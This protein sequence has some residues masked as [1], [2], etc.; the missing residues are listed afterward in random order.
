MA[1]QFTLLMGVILGLIG[2]ALLAGVWFRG[3]VRLHEAVRAA[4]EREL[5]QEKSSGRAAHERAHALDRQLVEVNTL[6]A[7]ERRAAEEK[8][9]VLKDA[10]E[11]LSN[12]FKALANEI[13]EDKSR[14]FTEQNRTS[15][16]QLLD[17]LK[18]KLTEFQAKVE[19]VYVKESNGRSALEREVHR[20]AQ[21]NQMLSED[22]RNLTNALK[23]SHKI[24]GN[25]G[26]LVLERVLDGCG[27]RKGQ[28]YEVQVRYGAE[29]GTR[30]QPDV[31]I[32]LPEGRHLV[33]DAK[34]S[35]TAYAEYVAAE[36]EGAREEAM[37]RHVGSL[38]A[39]VAGLSGK[40]Y[41]NLPGLKTVDFVLLFVPI[42]P[43]FIAAVSYDSAILME[44]W[45]KNV[46]LVSPSTFFSVIR[47][48]SHLWS[49]EAQNRNAQEIARRGAQLYDRL[50]GFVGDLSKLGER[51]AQAQESYQGAFD[52]LHRN[53]GNVIWQAEKLRG[54]GV[55]PSKQLP[56]ALLAQTVSD[57]EPGLPPQADD[58]ETLAGS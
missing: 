19:D 17:P 15:L 58:G 30:A 9:A 23:G 28:E 37:K 14:R 6:L 55:K 33:V 46:L 40:Q 2:G 11:E 41:Q 3:R 42:E 49:Q 39:H 21:M 34:V 16:G 47:L 38:R 52:K 57:D 50:V 24:Q 1:A 22:A 5:G 4:L 10:K 27:L 45:Q 54:L 13:L 51:L 7:A 31:V 36:A 12:Q 48:V 56:P 53:Q 25:W 8:L 20:L 32:H 26:E 29:D 43:A 44:A 35:L 18:T